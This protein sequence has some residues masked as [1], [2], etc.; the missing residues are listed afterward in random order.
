MKE[1]HLTEV[2]GL[3]MQVNTHVYVQPR[4]L[5]HTCAWACASS[6]HINAPSYIVNHFKKLKKLLM[7]IFVEMNKF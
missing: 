1:L 4:A 7:S 3:H 5:M 2:T 6:T